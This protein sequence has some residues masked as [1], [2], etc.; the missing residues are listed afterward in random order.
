M[1]PP[2][3]KESRSRRTVKACVIC[4]KKKIRCDIDDIEG[5][6]CTPCQRDGYDCVLRERKRKRF[7]FS[8]SPPANQRRAKA[9][10]RD[11]NLLEGS[12]GAFS[13]LDH[14]EDSTIGSN[15]NP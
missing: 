12:E 11:R 2:K 5:E 6:V 4:H 15:D 13:T 14:A 8:P 1:A 7:T 3:G 10:H 9:Q